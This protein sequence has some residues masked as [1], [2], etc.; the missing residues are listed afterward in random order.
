MQNVMTEKRP[1]IA[2]E[3]ESKGILTNTWRSVRLLVQRI[4]RRKHLLALARLSNAELADIG[5]T[6]DDIHESAALGLSEDV[7]C[8]LGKIAIRRR[9]GLYQS[10]A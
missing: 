1:M 8:H 5:I 6:R 10:G 7:T 9:A 3:V 2:C 4:S